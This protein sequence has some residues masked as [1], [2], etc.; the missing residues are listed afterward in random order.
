MGAE[1]GFAAATV[2][3]DDAVG[4]RVGRGEA[5]LEEGE[6]EVVK[7]RGVAVD[8]GGAGELDVEVGGDPGVEFV[9]GGG[10]GREIG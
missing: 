2:G 4:G 8:D 6:D 10:D 5:A 9:G 1:E 7:G 3:P